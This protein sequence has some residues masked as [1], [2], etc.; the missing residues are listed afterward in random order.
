[1]TRNTATSDGGG[2]RLSYQATVEINACD[3]SYNTGKTCAVRR[4]GGGRGGVK[5][6]VGVGGDRGGGKRGD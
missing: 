2:I 1:M 3:I 4:A 6:I 5:G